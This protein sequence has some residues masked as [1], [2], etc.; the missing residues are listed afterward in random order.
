MLRSTALPDNT[1]DSAVIAFGIRNV[2]DRRAGLE[3]IRR[4]LRPGGRLVVLEL[5]NPRPGPVR[6]LYHCYFRR[7]LPALGS[8][9]SDAEAYR[10]LPESVLAFPDTASFSGM[11]TTAGF[12]HVR[13]KG[14]TLGIATL[15]TGDKPLTP[16]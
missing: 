16:S 13:H 2:G 10:Y 5:A 11:M 15:F 8:L 7:F 14:L 4:V 1:F 9:F 12:E 6:A 3:E